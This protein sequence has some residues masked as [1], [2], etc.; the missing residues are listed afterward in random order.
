[1][2]RFILLAALLIFML[3]TL[4]MPS[5]LRAQA[6]SPCGER[7]FTSHI[8]IDPRAFCLELISANESGAGELAYTSLALGDEG[9]LYAAR[10][11]TGQIIVFDDSDGDKLP[12]AP[13]IYVNGLVLPNAL[14][15]HD[16][17]LYVAGGSH[18]YRIRNGVVETLAD[19]VP[20]G[21]FWISGLAV[22]TTGIYVAVSADCATCIDAETLAEQEA[23]VL[24][25]SEL[26]QAAARGAILRYPLDGG[27]PEVWA[28]GLH[29]PGDLTFYRGELWVSDTTPS[30]YEAVA[31]LDEINRVVQDADFGFPMCIGAT[32][33]MT[34]AFCMIE[35]IPPAHSLPTRST[36]IGMAAYRGDALPRLRDSLLV[37]LAG[38]RNNA[39]LQGYQV[40]AL[41][42]EDASQTWSE[43]A[44]L[45]NGDDWADASGERFTHQQMSYRGSGFFPR[46]PLDVAVSAEGWVYIS[47]Q[48]GQILV[49]R[50]Q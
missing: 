49:V 2:L 1:M 43:Y 17:V 6:L 42:L 35:A 20:S 19:S 10:P 3:L 4:H 24:L 33:D 12:D 45:P 26:E 11:L 29:Q 39:A 22:D 36:P 47:V 9:E 16:D 23:A 28:R 34:G 40:V 50:P 48:G 30:Q 41:T 5:H 27:Q 25:A 32:I 15:W 38:N 13:R 8:W 21:M 46:R 37:V 18:L 44:L 7:Q 31:D 14:A